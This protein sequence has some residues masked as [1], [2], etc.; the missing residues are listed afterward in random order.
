MRQ[1][2][3]LIFIVYDKYKDISTNT[4][5]G[6]ILFYQHPYNNSDLFVHLSSSEKFNSLLSVA[7]SGF[8]RKKSDTMVCK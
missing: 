4:W 3:S 2:Y 7:L 6:N 8:Q 1:R 5:S